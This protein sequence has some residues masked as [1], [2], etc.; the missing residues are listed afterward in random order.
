MH[1]A[2]VGL[3]GSGKSTVGPLL[4]AMLGLRFVDTDREVE[5]VAG[6]PIHRIFET[7]GEPGFRALEADQV[8][9]ALD[10]PP[11]VI[12]LGGGAVLN[13]EN[14]RLVWERA[15][16]IWLHADPGVLAQR[17]RENPTGEPRPLLDAPDPAG[18]LAELLAA[19]QPLYA[20]AHLRSDASTRGPHEIAAALLDAIGTFPATQG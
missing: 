2:L 10:A 5:R 20:A 4:A 1:V 9:R 17:L 11:S 13:P 16:V 15:L 3:S 12:S 8:R 7:R 19:R 14:R 6:M 18:R